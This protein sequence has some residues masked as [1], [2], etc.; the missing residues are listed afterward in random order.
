[1]NNRPIRA[2]GVASSAISGS[3]AGSNMIGLRP[4]DRAEF[5]KYARSPERF[6][7][8]GA[9]VGS[10]LSAERDTAGETG[11]IIGSLWLA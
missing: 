4:A 3:H 5:L 9:P 6:D 2:V 11:G 7:H 1:M 8:P 10:V